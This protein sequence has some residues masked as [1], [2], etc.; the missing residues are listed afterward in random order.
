[1]LL[2]SQQVQQQ[3]AGTFTYQQ[4]FNRTAGAMMVPVCAVLLHYILALVMDM[5]Q[6]RDTRKLQRLQDAKKS[7]VKELKVK[8]STLSL[9]TRRAASHCSCWLQC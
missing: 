3:P 6:R 2:V 7:M 8:P 4:H 9:A 1:M 5:Q